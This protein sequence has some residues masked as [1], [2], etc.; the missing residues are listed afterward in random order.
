M[1]QWLENILNIPSQYANSNIV[2]G[3]LALISVG[4]GS[5]FAFLLGSIRTIIKMF[6]ARRS[7][8]P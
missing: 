6:T 4:V 1:Y 3:C 5:V 8:R 2:Y 7:E